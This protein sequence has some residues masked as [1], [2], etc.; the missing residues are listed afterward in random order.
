MVRRPLL[1]NADGP[2]RPAGAPPVGSLQLR[3]GSDL[4]VI[5]LVIPAGSLIDSL[6]AID[7]TLESRPQGHFRIQVVS[8]H[9]F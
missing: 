3:V 4:D 2:C 8:N 6:E 1:A 5:A 7:G 9:N